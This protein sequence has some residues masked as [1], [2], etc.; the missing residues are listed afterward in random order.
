MRKIVFDIE[1]TNFFTDTGSSDPA[2][3][4]MSVVCIYDYETD[5]YSSYTKET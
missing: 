2:S 5:K 4:D 3:L 1:T